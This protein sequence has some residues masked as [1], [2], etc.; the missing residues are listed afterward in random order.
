[1]RTKVLMVISMLVMVACGQR[2]AGGTS[3]ACRPE[4]QSL[5]IDATAFP[6]G[7]V[8]SSPER[9]PDHHGA[10]RRCGVDFYVYDG[11]AVQ[12]IYQYETGEEASRE[13]TR[14]LDVFFTERPIDT[15]WEVPPLPGPASPAAD[16]YRL[17]CSIQGK[18]SMCRA[19]ARY[20]HFVVRFN[21]HMS[22]D[23]MT[24]ENLQ[25]V[26]RAINDKFN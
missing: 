6:E 5:L 24:Y 10:I 16:E 20:G 11:V 21:T 7:W 18:E 25:L 12:E 13:F 23:F 9:P 14:Q 4:V 2:S 26:L 1:M 8:A 15:P 17:A 22:P 19:L 3:S